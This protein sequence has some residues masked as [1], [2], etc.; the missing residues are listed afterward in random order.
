MN[1]KDLYKED[2]P[3]Q[4]SILFNSL[5]NKTIS[6]QIA[7]NELLNEH[8]T[9]VSAILICISGNSM[10]EDEN[11][12]LVNLRNGDFVIILPYIKHWVKANETSNFILIK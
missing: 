10:Y 3:V 6:M 5:E 9:K 8:T 11:G 4:S 7:K 1:L 2:K 12:T